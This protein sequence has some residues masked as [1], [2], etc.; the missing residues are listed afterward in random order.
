VLTLGKLTHRFIFY[1]FLLCFCYLLP[2]SSAYAF[3]EVDWS[4]GAELPFGLSRENIYN[5]PHQEFR[6]AIN[7]GRKHA[8]RWPVDVTGL[9][10]PYRPFAQFLDEDYNNP[11]RRWASRLSKAV[12]PFKNKEELFDWMGLLP[13]SEKESHQL[14]IFNG[15]MK[16]LYKLNPSGVSLM[17]RKGA[18]GLTFG[19]VSCHSGQFL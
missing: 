17:E 18:L 4:E 15:P 12:I 3:Q 5:L 8:Y 9:L 6:E 11:L 1:K 7:N 2:F 10:I 14:S 19:C 16:K 13:Y